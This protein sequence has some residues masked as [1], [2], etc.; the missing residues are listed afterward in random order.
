MSVK[1]RENLC[2]NLTQEKSAERMVACTRCGRWHLDAEKVLGKKLSCTDVKQ[3][4]SKIREEHLKVK[5]H[6]ARI[7]TDD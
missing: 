1:I 2:P 4:W 3:Y 5:G 7:S 6:P